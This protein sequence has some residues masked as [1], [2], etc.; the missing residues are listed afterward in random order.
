MR[1]L[2]DKYW[3]IK[4]LYGS[5]SAVP[6]LVS[7]NLCNKIRSTLPG[8]LVCFEPYYVLVSREKRKKKKRALL[9]RYIH[10]LDGRYVLLFVI[11]EPVA[12]FDFCE[13]S[14]VVLIIS[15]FPRYWING[16]CHTCLLFESAFVDTPI[17]GQRGIRENFVIA[18]T[19]Q[20]ELQYWLALFFFFYAMFFLFLKGVFSCECVADMV[21]G[22]WLFDDNTGLVEVKMTIGGDPNLVFS[23]FSASQD[24]VGTLRRLPIIRQDL[25]VVNNTVNISFVVYV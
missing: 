6:K 4:K 20:T 11:G 5:V 1:C 2:Q 24:C 15:H 3:H 7:P 17:T 16:C 8:S 9:F 21:S 23:Q 25:R 22:N 14:L 10:S 13:C 12:A 19:I 18:P